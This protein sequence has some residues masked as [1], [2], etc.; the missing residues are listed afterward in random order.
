MIRSGTPTRSRLRQVACAVAAGLASGLALVA[1][2]AAASPTTTAATALKGLANPSASMHPSHAFKVYC[3]EANHGAACNRAALADIDKARKAEGLRKLSLPSN[4]SSL[5]MPRQ[6]AALANRER[7]VRGL[8]S[9]PINGSLDNEAEQGAKEGTDPTG[10]SNYAW[11]SNLSWGYFTA[12]AADFAWMY[13][14]GPDSP[15]SACKK[16]GDAGCWGHRDNI[17]ARWKGA[18]GDGSYT[19]AG[20][21]QLTELFVRNY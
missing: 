18:Q 15:N 11:G 3:F 14:D 13:D 7:D 12:L 21:P 16:A 5:S 4:F 9:M 2:A 1:P 8:A 6:L 17:L 20:T 19:D 10:P